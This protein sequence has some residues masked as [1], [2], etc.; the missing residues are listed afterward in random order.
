[1]PDNKTPPPSSIPLP[2]S[3]TPLWGP[4][5][6]LPPDSPL[7]ALSDLRLMQA[8]TPGKSLP[9][10]TLLS[11]AASYRQTQ[12]LLGLP[13]TEHPLI[14]RQRQL[15]AIRNSPVVLGIPQ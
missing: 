10:E 7:T 11:L 6:E 13:V 8:R 1:M 12:T 9:L 2:P 15:E 5:Q 14:S 4:Q 3:A